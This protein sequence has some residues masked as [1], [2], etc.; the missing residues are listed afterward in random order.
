M[1]PAWLPLPRPRPRARIGLG[2]TGLAD[3][4]LMVGLRYGSDEAAAQT[5]AQKTPTQGQGHGLREVLPHDVTPPSPQRSTQGLLPLPGL[6][7]DQEEV[8]HVGA[9]DEEHEAYRAQEDPEGLSGV[10]HEDVLQWLDVRRQSGVER[11]PR[12]YSGLLQRQF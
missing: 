2:V 5:E 7:P 12:I 6:R 11:Y 9:G 1:I 10:L 3:A 4:L 8:R